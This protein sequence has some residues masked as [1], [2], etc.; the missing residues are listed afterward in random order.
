MVNKG[1]DQ[2]G[3]AFQCPFGL[4]Q[5]SI[6]FRQRIA[7]NIGQQPYFD[8]TPNPFGRV[9]FWSITWKAF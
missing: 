7:S 1:F 9:Q 4:L 5:E 3:F 2:I 8:V 6:N